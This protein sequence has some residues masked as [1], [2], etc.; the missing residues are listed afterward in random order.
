M[1]EFQTYT[2]DL[3]T[4]P[5]AGSGTFSGEVADLGGGALGG[6]PMEIRYIEKHGGLQLNGLHQHGCMQ[7]RCFRRGG[8]WIVCFGR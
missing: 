3:T 1:I 7:L 5:T 2:L 4:P 6:L 8:Q